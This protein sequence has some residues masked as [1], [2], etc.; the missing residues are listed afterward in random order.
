[1]SAASRWLSSCKATARPLPMVPS[2]ARPAMATTSS[3]G[4]AV[5]K[6]VTAA[7]KIPISTYS[8]PQDTAAV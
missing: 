7:P 1:M 8:T 3:L 4:N 2:R 5:S 6:P